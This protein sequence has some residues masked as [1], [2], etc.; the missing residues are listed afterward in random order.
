MKNIYICLLLFVV[1]SCKDKSLKP[2]KNK[3]LERILQ[4]YEVKVV[5]MEEGSGS[6]NERL[7]RVVL[8]SDLQNDLDR[9]LTASRIAMDFFNPANVSGQDFEYGKLEVLTDT[10]DVV[11]E[12]EDVQSAVGAKL[13]TDKFTYSLQNVSDTLKYVQYVDTT[14][15]YKGKVSQLK[16]SI[17]DLRK[18]GGRITDVNFL[19]YIKDAGFRDRFR[20]Y[21]I[22]NSEEK[23]FPV[24]ITASKTGDEV[25]IEKI[26]VMEGIDIMI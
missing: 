2:S 5:K 21:L 19:G 4:Q 3:S 24:V 12:K 7:L 17:A 11:F 6:E 15:Y 16:Q 14:G 8:T 9:K 26:D 1:F 23:S 13:Q 18:E 10:A 20:F 22:L 25:Q